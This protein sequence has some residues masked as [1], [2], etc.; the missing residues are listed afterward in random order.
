MATTTTGGDI[1]NIT[2][3]NLSINKLPNL[4]YNNILK[5]ICC[6]QLIQSFQQVMYINIFNL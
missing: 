1:R 4:Y 6:D 2:S 5:K 3:D